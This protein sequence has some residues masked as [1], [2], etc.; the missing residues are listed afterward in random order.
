MPVYRILEILGDVTRYVDSFILFFGTLGNLLSIC[1]FTRLTIFRG[2]QCAFYLNIEAFANI[3]ALMIQSIDRFTQYPDG[4]TLADFKFIWCRAR[5]FLDQCSQLIPFSIVCLT[6]FDQILSTSPFYS[7]RQLS[8]MKLARRSISIAI[9]A[10]II[11][12]IPA[13]FSFGIYPPVGCISIDYA[14]GYY[15]LFVYYPILVGILPLFLSSIFSLIAYRNVRRL[16]RRQIPMVRRRLDR[17]L[18]AMVFTR[19]ILMII[20]CL[21]FTIYR[22]YALQAVFKT[23]YNFTMIINRILRFLTNL[24]RNINHA[25]RIILTREPPRVILF[26]W[27]HLLLIGRTHSIDRS[28]KRI[29]AQSLLLLLRY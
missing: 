2:N 20:F 16:I 21:P 26:V 4:S 5:F 6:T 14:A 28:H 13:M 17:Q 25:V 19:V 22:I 23:N 24:L 27:A 10:S 18:T 11:H 8:T 3:F 9:I 12:S 7:L 1:V 15:Y 29:C